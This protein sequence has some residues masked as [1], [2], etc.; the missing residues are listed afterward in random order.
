MPTGGEHQVF[1][2]THVDHLG[3][4]VRRGLLSDAVIQSGG[5]FDH[6]AGDRSIKDRRRHR[7]VPCGPGGVV[8]DYVPF[9]FAPRSPMLYRIT[10][11]YSLSSGGVATYRGSPYELVYLVTTVETLCT[12]HLPLVLTDRNAAANVASFSDD[13][14]R[15]FADGFIDWPLM[16]QAM[17]KSTAED[18]DRMDRRAAECLV[19]C[20]LPW[21]LITQLAVHDQ[22]IADRARAALAGA[23]DNKTVP[24]LR[25]TWYF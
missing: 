4:I 5:E 15:W 23:G 16:K 6:E 8:A 11:P 20:A 9:Y 25:P 2:F 22:A 17:W 14:A 21:R 3:E 13:P 7:V 10:N 19:H 1:H 18:P 24:V 12:A